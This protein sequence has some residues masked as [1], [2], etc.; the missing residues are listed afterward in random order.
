M[1]RQRYRPPQSQAELDLQSRLTRHVDILAGVIGPRHLGRPSSFEATVAYIDQQFTGLGKP[2]RYERYDINGPSVANLVVEQEGVRRPNEVVILGAHYDTVPETPGADD[3]AS[4]VAMLLEV[5]RLL[6]GISVKRTVRFVAFAC[7]EPP[8]FYTDTM[9]SQVHARGCR[10]RGEHIVGMIC[11][12][13]VGYYTTE[14]DSQRAPT[15]IPKVLRWILPSR[16]DFL[17]AVGNLKSIRLLRA[18]RGGY[19]RNGHLPL[20]S[21]AL[22][23]LVNAIRLSDNG[24]FWDEGYSAL[25]ITDTSF[26]RNP[27][28]HLQSDTPDTLDYGRLT[29]ATLGVANAIRH[30]AGG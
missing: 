1:W 23:E 10:Q 19:R 22:P 25:M 26:L 13:M 18:F 27:H 7:E 4:A 30:L 17:A 20:F 21:I 6:H 15:E 28:Y 29:M 12:E 14:R 2:P 24:P 3:N 5:A 11:L 9:G 8:H 16:G